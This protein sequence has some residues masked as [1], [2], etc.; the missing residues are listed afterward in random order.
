MWSFCKSTYINE[1]LSTCTLLSYW[2]ELRWPTRPFSWT[3]VAKNCFD[4]DED[5][6]NDDNDDDKDTS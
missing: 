4:E 3:K 2:K 6:Y 5:D 1:I